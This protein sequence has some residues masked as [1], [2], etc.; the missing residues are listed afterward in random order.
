MITG[1]TTFFGGSPFATTTL[2]RFES[3]E[4]FPAEFVAVR[5]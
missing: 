5:W 4:P 2:L 1:G 3:M